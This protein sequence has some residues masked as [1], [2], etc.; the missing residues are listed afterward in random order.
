MEDLYIKGCRMFFK[1][2]KVIAFFLLAKSLLKNILFQA[3]SN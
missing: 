2:I 1:E 3:E